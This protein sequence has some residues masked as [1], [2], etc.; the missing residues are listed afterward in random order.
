M[1]AVTAS[2]DGTCTLANIPRGLRQKSHRVKFA[3]KLFRLDFSRRTG[4]YRM[5]DNLLPQQ[6]TTVDVAKKLKKAGAAKEK[7]SD[8]GKGKGK[9]KGAGPGFENNEISGAWSVEVGVLRA[10]WFPGLEQAR[11]LASGMACG[12]VRVDWVDKG[13]EP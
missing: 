5:L 13:P 3:Q 8:K 9:G 7:D 12:L 2:A 4:E 1:F 11:L 6:R 10:A